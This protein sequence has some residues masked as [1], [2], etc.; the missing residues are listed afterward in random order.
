MQRLRSC[1]G[2]LG[3]LWSHADWDGCVIL[4]SSDEDGVAQLAREAGLAE[5]T[6]YYHLARLASAGVIVRERVGLAQGGRRTRFWFG[7]MEYIKRVLG[8]LIERAKTRIVAASRTLPASFFVPRPTA[9]V[10]SSPQ[11]PTAKVC[12]SPP[13]DLIQE[14]TVSTTIA[15]GGG[16]A[17]AI[18][19]A[20][21]PAIASSTVSLEVDRLIE[22]AERRLGRGLS[23]LERAATNRLLARRGR[24]TDEWLRCQAYELSGYGLAYWS[25]KPYL[26]DCALPDT[27]VRW[28]L[29]GYPASKPAER[30]GS[31]ATANRR[32]LSD[33][34]APHSSSRPIPLTM[35]QLRATAVAGYCRQCLKISG[36]LH[37]PGCAGGEGTVA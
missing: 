17:G 4:G 3:V 28:Q 24:T 30:Q 1:M 21:A 34:G 26:A 36:S 20:S 18:A 23:D 33:G 37:D 5:R 35:E 16:G 15:N 11:N 14:E 10:C 8:G 13:P 19:G 12:S 31:S 29:R 27:W 9:K 6:V 25:D 22:D 7:R 2:T 32:S